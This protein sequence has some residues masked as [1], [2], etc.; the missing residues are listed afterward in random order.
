MNIVG[1][2][3]PVAEE[4]IGNVFPTPIT[5][6]RNNG[7]E[8]DPATGDV[9][10]NSTAFAINAGVLSSGRSEQGGVG[11]DHE[12]RL[13]IHHGAAGLPHLPTT[14]D[15]VEYGGL[16]WK[17]TTIDPTYRSDAL[18]ASKITARHQ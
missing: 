8:Y 14:A 9:T 15:Q 18:I 16:T 4:L 1:T 10:A 3:L 13:W 7:G 2:F 12:L 17:V 11:E 5:Y 6:I